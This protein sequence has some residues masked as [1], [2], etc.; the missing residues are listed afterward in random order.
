VLIGSLF[1]IAGLLIGLSG[2]RWNNPE[3]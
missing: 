1:I 3:E 2:M